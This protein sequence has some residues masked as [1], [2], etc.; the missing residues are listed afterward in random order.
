MRVRAKYSDMRKREASEIR[1]SE[2]AKRSTRG[3][4]RSMT[5][6]AP[7]VKSPGMEIDLR[8]QRVDEAITNLD[9]YIDAA[10]LSGLPFG[11]IIHGKGTGRLRTAVRDYLHNHALVSKVTG[12]KPN[13][14]GSGVTVAYI[15]PQ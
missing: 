2:R 9:R 14:G 1:E 3:S 8:G 10:Y 11:R 15:A 13:E 7:E 5:T 4:G 12:A 6:K